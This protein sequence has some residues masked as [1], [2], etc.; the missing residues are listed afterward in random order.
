[1]CTSARWHP[2]QAFAEARIFVRLWMLRQGV[3]STPWLHILLEH[4]GVVVAKGSAGHFLQL[5][6]SVRMYTTL[7]LE[8]RH[9][10]VKRQVLPMAPG[11]F[12]WCE[13]GIVQI[14]KSGGAVG[15]HLLRG[16]ER[17]VLLACVLE[18]TRVDIGLCLEHGAVCPFGT[19]HDPGRDGRL[20]GGP[21]W[22]KVLAVH[23]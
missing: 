11:C 10:D 18:S 7:G 19:I 22:A 16:T 6:R 1:M 20:P 3:K 14:R 2:A 15:G 17:K 23:A 5:H 9:K 12:D 21:S 8:S 13:G 4:A